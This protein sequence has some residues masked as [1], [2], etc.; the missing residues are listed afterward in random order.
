MKPEQI[1]VVQNNYLNPLTST[2]ITLGRIK[3]RV[4]G[5]ELF[6]NVTDIQSF[7]R[8]LQPVEFAGHL[9]VLI[10]FKISNKK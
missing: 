10:I 8:R 1:T 3:G 9:L 5:A 2:V 6:S 4:R 7:S